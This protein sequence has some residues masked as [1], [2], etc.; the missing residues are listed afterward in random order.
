MS[1]QIDSS[2][3]PKLFGLYRFWFLLILIGSLFWCSG[4]NAQSSEKLISIIVPTAAEGSTD[5]LARILGAGLEAQGFGKVIVKNMPGKSGSIAADYVAKAEPDG[6]TLLIGTPSSHSIAQALSSD[7]G[8]PLSYDP[9]KSFSLIVCF[10]QAPYI[11][12]VGPDGPSSIDEFL[13]QAKANSGVWK[14][15]STGV[16]GPHHLIAEYL[17]SNVGL[18]LQHVPAAGGAKAIELVSTNQVQTMLPASILALP[19]AKSNQIKALAVTGNQRLKALPNIPTFSELGISLDLVSWYGLMAPA[20]ISQE[21]TERLAAAVKTIFQ[22]PSEQQRLVDLGINVIDERGND[23][24][25][26]IAQETDIWKTVVNK[27][28]MRSK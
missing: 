15:S 3:R 2:F 9:I 25:K 1:L 5:Q 11:L 6:R 27:M 18:S 26:K 22:S 23:F 13:K 12:V 4:I 7:G 19:Q 10:A 24:E 17:F 16:G 14:Y 28:N 8:S 21:Q 20:G